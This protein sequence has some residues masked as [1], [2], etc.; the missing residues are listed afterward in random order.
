MIDTNALNDL[1]KRLA[2]SLPADF[3]MLKAD[4]EKNFQALLQASFSRMNLVSR[5]DF[6]VQQA[7]LAR[8]R[9]RLES[10]EARV[11]ALENSATTK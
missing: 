11:A 10:L 4:M 1:A 8:A 2:E 3:Q 7:L 6:E 5:E 9:E